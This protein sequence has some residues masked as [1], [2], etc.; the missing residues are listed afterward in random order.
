MQAH[1]VTIGSDP[2]LFLKKSGAFLS[3]FGLFKGTKQ[4]PEKVNYGAVQ[5]DGM[6]LEFNTDPAS[7]PDEFINN[8]SAVLQQIRE[9]L[10]PD[11]QFDDKCSVH[12]DSEF[13]YEQPLE[14][15]E[16]GCDPDMNAYTLS[17]NPT[18]DEDS[19]MRT[20]GG[21]VHIGWGDNLERHGKKCAEVA[22]ACDLLLGVPSVL[23]DPDKERREL[24]GKAGAFRIKPY[25]VE[26]RTLSSFW[27]H[28]EAYQRFVFQQATQAYTNLDNYQSMLDQ[29]GIT[30][31][32]VQRV[33]DTSDIWE[34]AR[35]VQALGIKLP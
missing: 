3:A 10:E 26:Y 18:P 7:T 20:A 19:L 21:H 17:Y 29:A 13:F 27:V 14:A 32:D 30:P 4:E 28:K 11:V 24:Y 34:A 25:G 2:E 1:A 5:V 22:R 33:I 15:R 12:F 9:R 23:L 8:I 31:E 6:A 16:M 35:I